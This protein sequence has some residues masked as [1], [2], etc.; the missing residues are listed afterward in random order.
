MILVPKPAMLMG[1]SRS[2]KRNCGGK[3][4]TARSDKRDKRLWHKSIR[5]VIRKWI[6]GVTKAYDTDDVPVTPRD[7]DAPHADTWGWDSDGGSNLRVTD[8][9]I[10]TMLEQTFR[11]VEKVVAE[12]KRSHN[13]L[14]SDWDMITVI[15][16]F[17][18]IESAGEVR[19]FLRCREN[20]DKVMCLWRRLNYGK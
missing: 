8:S 11:N 2:Y 14:L 12:Y 16:R 13:R 3:I 18:R 17:I 9:D 7:V 4:T 5:T 19:E 15:A 10:R 6:W 1:M 20:C